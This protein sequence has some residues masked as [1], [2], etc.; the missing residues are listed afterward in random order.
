MFEVGGGSDALVVG[1]LEACLGLGRG[2][3][4][5]LEAGEGAIEVDSCDGTGIGR[6][7]RAVSDL[8]FSVSKRL[9]LTI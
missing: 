6:G 5:V 9:L 1:V 2:E 3:D 8:Q 7:N 4:L